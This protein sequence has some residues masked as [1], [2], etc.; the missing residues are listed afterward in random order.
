[1]TQH[2]YGDI[3]SFGLGALSSHEADVL[4]DHADRCATCAVLVAE[5]MHGVAALDSATAPRDIARPAAYR[6]PTRGRAGRP[7]S[8][9]AAVASAAALAL[10]AWNLDL[11]AGRSQLPPTP[12]VALVHSHFNHHPLSGGQGAGA[13]KAIVAA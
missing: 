5:A 13:A 12:V 2:P 8:T 1:M 10:F 4:L 9:V 7:W 11:R 6:A 3:E